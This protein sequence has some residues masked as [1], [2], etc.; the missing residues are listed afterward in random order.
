MPKA[1]SRMESVLVTLGILLLASLLT[2]PAKAIAIVCV[3]L[4]ATILF[5]GFV[6]VLIGLLGQIATMAFGLVKRYGAQKAT[7][8]I[9]F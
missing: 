9:D 1:P 2:Y 8:E 5:L 7:P 3:Q 6:L 4:L